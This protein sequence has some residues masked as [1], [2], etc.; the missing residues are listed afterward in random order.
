MKLP[1]MRFIDR[2]AGVPLCWVF[3]LFRRFPQQ[4]AA[5]PRAVLAI[6]FFG[7][8]SVLLTGTAIRLLKK[9]FP[10]TRIFYLTF[11]D[12]EEIA[13]LLP[14]IDEVMCIETR[15][16]AA[17][18]TS[19][20][21]VVKCLRKQSIDVVLDFEFFSKFSTFVGA[22][23]SPTIHIGFSLPTRWRR[24]N[25]SHA[26]RL[27]NDRHV[28]NTFVDMLSPLGVRGSSR[29]PS[30]PGERG[31]SI[32]GESSADADSD[33]ADII[34]VNPNAGE[35]SLDR[36]WGA[37]N[38]AEMLTQLHSRFPETTFCLIGSRGEREYVQAIADSVHPS[39]RRIINLAGLT[40][41]REL[42]TLFRRSRMLITNDSGPMH[43]AAA[44]GL[45]TVALFGPESPVFYGPIGNQAI[46]LYAHFRCSP[47]LNIYDAKVF[48][49]PIGAA[50]MDEIPV[51][52]V[53]EAA[54][55]LMQPAQVATAVGS[56]Y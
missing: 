48:R 8:G 31:V 42:I 26:V 12:N 15:S 7:M 44:L 37:S 28:S 54:T 27:D 14:F 34:C 51:S 23:A 13:A 47:C 3:G 35:T 39:G 33:S 1:T 21:G 49:C 29:M 11:R 40:T 30:P 56:E 38:Y 24:W 9:K 5:A 45:P 2:Y 46:N 22:L 55:S 52:R 53:I 6:K 4:T 10:T 20:M 18:L 25:L 50:C 43:L 41:V 32:T 17:F 16:A 36:R 19:F